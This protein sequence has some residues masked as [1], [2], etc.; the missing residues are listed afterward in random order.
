MSQLC[1]SI[2]VPGRSMCSILTT[3]MRME[4]SFQHHGYPTP[5]LDWTYSPYVAAFFAYRG[6]SNEK[7]ASAEASARVRIHVFDQ[8]SWKKDINQILFVVAPSRLL[9]N[10][11]SFPADYG[12]RRYARSRSSAEPHVQLFVAGDASAERSSAARHPGHGG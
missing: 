5:L 9:K 4:L 7:A 11:S 2:S 10:Y 1:T 3:Q 12:T 8:E 6:I